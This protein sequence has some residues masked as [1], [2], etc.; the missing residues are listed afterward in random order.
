MWDDSD[1]FQ[2]LWHLSRKRFFMYPPIFLAY[3]FIWWIVRG[4]FYVILK[5]NF[6]FRE[7]HAQRNGNCENILP[8]LELAK[9]FFYESAICE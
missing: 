9:G 4:T 8:F 3:L 7:L 5:Y 2:L 1:I 6:W